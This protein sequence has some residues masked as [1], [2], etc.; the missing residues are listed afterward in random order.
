MARFA[1]LVG[2]LAGLVLVSAAPAFADTPELY[3]IAY[4]TALGRSSD[5]ELDVTLPTSAPAAA[6][7][8]FYSP[9]G[10][11]VAVG[12]APG[13]K[14]G[15]VVAGVTVGGS[16]TEIEADGDLLAD[17]PA[18]YVGNACAPGLHAG[19]LV[20]SLAAGGVTVPVPLYVY[21]TSGAEAAL[22]GFKIQ[23]CLASPDVPAAIGGAPAGLRLLEA[24]LDFTSIFTNPAATGAYTWSVFETPYT[25]GTAT[26]NPAGTVEA[27]SIVS[28]PKLFSVKWALN[29][30]KTAVTF[31]GKVNEGGKPRAGVNVRF[32]VSK[33]QLGPWTAFGVAQTKADGSFTLTKAVTASV[34][35]FAHVN[36]YISDSCTAAGSTAPGGCVFESTGPSFGP[37]LHVVVPPKAKKK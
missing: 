32:L 10:Y 36:P 6:S 2:I 19:V 17:D 9:Q 16:T 24:D 14:V 20:A 26:P 37:I 7:V 8:V 22:G 34:Y 12:Q 21:P 3:A 28:L 13:T 11:D 23:A 30:K 29:A 33:K 35:V 5:T 25:P 15:T 18:K 4:D 1:L 31:K 27:R